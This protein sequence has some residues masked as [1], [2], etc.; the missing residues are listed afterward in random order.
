MHVHN[1]R[2]IKNVIVKLFVIFL[3]LRAKVIYVLKVI[4]HENNSS[5]FRKSSLDKGKTHISVSLWFF[6]ILFRVRNFRIVG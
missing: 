5:K 6:L 4:T 1:I 2:L 3:D